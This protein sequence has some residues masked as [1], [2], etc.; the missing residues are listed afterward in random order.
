MSLSTPKN[1]ISTDEI[2]P[3][4]T[5]TIICSVIGGLLVVNILL[6]MKS[7]QYKQIEDE[8]NNPHSR[9]NSAKLS[10]K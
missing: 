1:T 6:C 10:N 5:A 4:N 3:T 7:H 2:W 9:R 8:I